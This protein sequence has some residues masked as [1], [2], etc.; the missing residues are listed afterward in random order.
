MQCVYDNDNQ[1][2][3]VALDYI[4]TPALAWGETF[5]LNVPSFSTAAA[6]DCSEFTEHRPIRLISSSLFINAFQVSKTLTSLHNT[7]FFAGF[8]KNFQSE[9][10]KK[11]YCIKHSGH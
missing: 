7:L 11:R 1:L 8:S 3:I 5:L 10:Q 2:L 6:S 4:V 9:Q